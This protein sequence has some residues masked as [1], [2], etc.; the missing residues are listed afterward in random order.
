MRRSVMKKQSPIEKERR[1]LARQEQAFLLAHGERESSAL[2]RLLEDRVPPGLRGTLDEAFFRAFRLMFEK[3]AGLIELSYSREK[4][5]KALE[6]RQLAY[7]FWQDRRSLGSITQK[8]AG[9]G[10]LN[11]LLSGVAGLGLGVL[12]IGLPD[13]ALFT[14]LMLKCVYETALNYGFDYRSD[15]EKQFVLTVI[16]GAMASGDELYAADR[17]LNDWIALPE[18][19]RPPLGET[20]TLI[21]AA[22]AQLSGELLYMKFLQG[23]PIVGAVGGAYDAVYMRRISR[24]AELKYRRRYCYSPLWRFD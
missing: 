12:G 16:Q 11:G 23:I 17:R 9:S 7:E 2:E 3:G 20:Q 14:A 15:A 24:Y 6:D 21:R 5:A 22:A 4:L 19:E 1:R 13:I 10:R 8:A 18:G